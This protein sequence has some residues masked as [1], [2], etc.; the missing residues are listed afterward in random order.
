M[1]TTRKPTSKPRAKPGRRAAKRPT[2][3]LPT[4]TAFAALPLAEHTALFA[5]WL[6]RQSGSYDWGDTRDCPLGRFGTELYRAPA[7]GCVNRVWSPASEEGDVTWIEVFGDTN[8]DDPFINALSE[9]RTF[10]AAS[11]AFNAAL[12]AQRS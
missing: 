11:R 12:R 4:A 3:R 6:A 8:E 10:G 2:F 9:N 7:T 1:K 5:R